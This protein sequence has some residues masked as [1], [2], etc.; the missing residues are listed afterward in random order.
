MNSLSG[1]STAFL[2]L[3]TVLFVLDAGSLV[4]LEPRFGSVLDASPSPSL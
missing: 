2:Y 3:S 1:R 4:P